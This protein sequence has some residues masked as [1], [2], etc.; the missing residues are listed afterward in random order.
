MQRNYPKVTLT[1]TLIIVTLILLPGVFMSFEWCDSGFYLTFY[2]NIFS[3]PESVEYN[4]MYYL[5]G[6]IG[7]MID[8][9][10]STYGLLRMRIAGLLFLLGS[11]VVSWRYSGMSSSSF[12]KAASIIC[13]YAGYISFPITLS[14]DIVTLL[15]LSGC[16]Y[17][18]VAG[19]LKSSRPLVFLS[20]L[21]TGFLIFVR[22]PN[23]LQGFLILLIPIYYSGGKRDK[24]ILSALY[25]GGY[26]AAILIMIILMS[27]LGHLSIFAQNLSTLVNLSSD[28]EASHGIGNLIYTQFYY[29]GSIFYCVFKLSV[30]A[31]SVWLIRIIVNSRLLRLILSF[32][33]AAYF[34]YMSIKIPPVIM[35][36]AVVV[37][38]LIIMS[39]RNIGSKESLISGGA[40]LSSL[41]FPLGSDGAGGNVG[42]ILYLLGAAPA[43]GFW[44][45]LH[46]R[47]KSHCFFIPHVGTWGAVSI[48]FVISIFNMVCCGL[49][50]D[51]TPLW[52]STALSDSPA[53]K[54][55]LISE[56][57]KEVVDEILPLLDTYVSPGDT[58]FSF[59]SVP[60]LNY[61]TSTRPFI[62]NS[63]P[64]QVSARRLDIL[65]KEE[66][67]KGQ[68]PVICLQ[69]FRTIGNQWG[70]PSHKFMI[71]EDADT[72]A[73]HSARKWKVVDGFIQRNDYQK[74]D[75]TEYFVIFTR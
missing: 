55:I 28:S 3:S 31:F 41:I 22:I 8:N 19:I 30:I 56:E 29:Y 51:D 23:L 17:L 46:I 32:P 20:G 60:M 13:I 63:W 16:V 27:A 39:L 15:M 67:R 21:M 62:G 66:E 48:F 49:Y 58:L 9:M 42:S 70:K 1:A 54:G 47:V 74:V 40:L 43:L 10:G 52:K 25:A 2:D 26:V 59:G 33:F 75:S 18:L 37:P 69:R 50:F 24:W 12:V 72:N 68:F 64:E 36:G 4:F 44:L 38:A 35:I 6:I 53:L 61:L 7:G 57:R 71:G 73:Y 5:S 11:A 14:Y 65:L 45:N 34:V